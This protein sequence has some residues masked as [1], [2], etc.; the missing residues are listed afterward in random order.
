MSASG[1]VF[2]ENYDDFKFY[3]NPFSF[4]EEICIFK[5]FVNHRLA[6]EMKA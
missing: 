5:C 6:N 2:E 3:V 4:T 1:C